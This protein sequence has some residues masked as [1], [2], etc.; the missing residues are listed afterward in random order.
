MTKRSAR[1]PGQAASF[2][3]ASLIICILL[4]QSYGYAQSSH[5]RPVAFEAAS[6]RPATNQESGGEGISRSQIQA[7]ANSLTM[8]NIDLSEM[9]EWAYGLEHY[10]L[11]GPR[12]LEGQR[13][14]VRAKAGEHL[15]ESTLKLMLQDLLATRFKLQL[16]REQKRTSVYE[17]VAFFQL[18]VKSQS[19][20]PV[21]TL[22]CNPGLPQP[23]NDSPC[24][25][26]TQMRPQT[27]FE[28]PQTQPLVLV[29]PCSHRCQFMSIGTGCVCPRFRGAGPPPGTRRPQCIGP[30][31]L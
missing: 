26:L 20:Q 2:I 16:H 24:A 22:D 25:L 19:G 1:T 21:S 29:L 23:A 12:I 4:A 15:A 8:R 30:E 10:Q 3:Q 7:G 17:L 5:A 11:T 27:H 13:Y 18:M 28:L 6:V 31:K 9:I 14:D